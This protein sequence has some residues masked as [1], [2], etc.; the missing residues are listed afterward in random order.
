M[1]SWFWIGLEQIHSLYFYQLTVQCHE[2][3]LTFLYEHMKPDYTN[4][5]H[6][7]NYNGACVKKKKESPLL[8]MS[9]CG[10]GGI[11]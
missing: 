3:L 6:I 10:L 7:L 11:Y 4:T 9:G 8:V 1:W 2:I 5:Q